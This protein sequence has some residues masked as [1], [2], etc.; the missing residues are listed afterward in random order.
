MS[1]NLCDTLI[2]ATE[3][4][5]TEDGQYIRDTVS[6]NVRCVGKCLPH[7]F[8][9]LYLFQKDEIQKLKNQ[10]I[11]KEVLLEESRSKYV[12]TDE[13]LFHIACC[14]DKLNT[15]RAEYEM[16]ALKIKKQT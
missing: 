13:E 10:L 1:A 14:F 7:L 11:S 9:T 8:K 12:K 3:S 2:Q 4:M 6:R 15:Q 5:N 16:E